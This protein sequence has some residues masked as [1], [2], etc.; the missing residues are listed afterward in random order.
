MA[1]YKVLAGSAVRQKPGIL[2]EFLQSLLELD[3]AGITV[4]FMFVNDNELEKS[5][6]LLKNFNPPRSRVHIIEGDKTDTY[7]CDEKKHQWKETLIWKVADYKD[8]IISYAREKNYDF[9][10]LIDSDLVLHPRTL[11]HLISTGRDIIS[12]IF[13][14]K[15][16]PELPPLPQVWVTDQYN[17][18]H[19]HRNQQLTQEEINSRINGYLNCLKIPGVYEV[20]GLGACTLISKKALQAGV[21]YKEIKNLSFWGEDRHFCIRASALGFK[22]YVDTHYPAYHIYRESELEGV[23]GYKNWCRKRLFNTGGASLRSRTKSENNKLTLSML[24]RNEAGRYL[25]QV[26]KHAAEYIDEAVILDDASEDD[27]AAVCREILKDIPLTLVSNKTP[28][29]DNEIQLRKQQWELTVSTGPDWILCLDADE[30]FEDRVKNEIRLLINQPYYDYFAFRLYD[31]WDAHHYREDTY[32]QAHKFYRPFLIRYQPN[33]NYLW[34]ETS[35]HCGRLPANIIELPGAL[36]RLRIKHFGWADV[37]DRVDKYQRY[38]RLDP[39]GKHGIIQQ[40]QS[41]LDP[42]P[43][44]IKWEE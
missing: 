26:L 43:R 2:S 32:W 36:S 24:V 34:K 14:T 22:L 33:F 37:K 18:Y 13:W 5:E 17:L 29:F 4:D 6:E 19:K 28:G 3:T 35:L 40:Y 10:F 8:R 16:N 23:A 1:D 15:W 31:F 7:T 21:S 41:I 9:L 12:E 27:T 11:V 42:N 38:M 30:I 25:P 44:L 39:G 20:G